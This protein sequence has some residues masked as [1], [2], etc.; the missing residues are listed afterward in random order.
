MM[1]IIRADV[2]R[3]VRG[4]ALYITLAVLLVYCVLTVGALHAFQ[5]GA[6]NFGFTEEALEEVPNL[7]NMFEGPGVCSVTIL[8]D[9][10]AQMENIV[11]FLL[12]VIIVVAGAI[13]SH[14]TVKN[15]LAWGISRTKLYFSKLILNSAIC[16]FM[17]LV[18]MGFMV[19]IAAIIGSFGGPAPAG[20][21][22]GLLQ[23]YSAQL[24]MLLAY[25]SFGVFL[26]FTTKRT[27]AV[28]GAFIA[29]IFVP[30]LLLTIITTINTDLQ[31]LLDFEMST[32]LTRLARLPYLETREIV[33]ALGIGTFVLAASTIGGVALF[34]R[35]EIK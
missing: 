5:S 20:H 2:Y 6:I 31:W 8:N 35:A 28:N 11:F 16:V 12:P 4:K 7:A 17:L 1:N 33:R 14:N 29:F 18:Y 23:I 10:A 19:I 25:V 34:K 13:F 26:A 15:D 32:N 24:V 22:V 9:A 21:W 3:I 27:A 30:L